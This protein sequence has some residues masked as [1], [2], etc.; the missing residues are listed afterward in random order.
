M[1]PCQVHTLEMKIGQPDYIIMIMSIKEILGT[2]TCCDVVNPP[3]VISSP[4]ADLAS[5]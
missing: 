2:A 5:S 1:L 4:L 3:L